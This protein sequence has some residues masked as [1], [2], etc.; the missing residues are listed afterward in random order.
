MFKK[1]LLFLLLLVSQFFLPPLRSV[2]Y[3][4]IAG[5]NIWLEYEDNLLSIS[6]NEADIK[7]VLLKISDEANIYVSFPLSLEKK[8]TIKKD[9]ISLRK[10]LRMLLNNTNY[11]II[12][13]GPNKDQSRVSG[14]IVFAKTKKTNVNNNRIIDRVDTLERQIVTYKLKLSEVGENSRAGKNY[15][16]Q[17][18]NIERNIESLERRIN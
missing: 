9:E 10:A 5:Q 15:L 14:V 12:Y 3:A 8:I 6:T 1:S 13:S 7:N 17:I 11:V 16:M 4:Q 2:L 18:R